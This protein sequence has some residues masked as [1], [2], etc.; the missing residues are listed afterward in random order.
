[1]TKK[2]VKKVFTINDIKNKNIKEVMKAMDKNGESALFP[3]HRFATKF[4]VKNKSKTIE[5]TMEFPIDQ[6]SSEK[7]LGDIREVSN[8]IITEESDMPLIPMIAVFGNKATVFPD[9]NN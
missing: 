4:K 1:M 5:I 7:H 2:K 8:V 9:R 3:I 6:V